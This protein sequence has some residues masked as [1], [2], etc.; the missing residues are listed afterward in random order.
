[1]FHCLRFE[2]ADRGWD[3][4]IIII[5]FFVSVPLSPLGEGGQRGQ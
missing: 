4:K 2:R 5:S 3:T 1:M